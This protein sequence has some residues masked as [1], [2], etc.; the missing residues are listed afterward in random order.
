MSR[1]SVD[2]QLEI[3]G[4]GVVPTVWADMREPLQ[5][6][7]A[8]GR[9]LRVKC[10]FDPTA[11]DLHIG[12]TVVMNK[13][14]QF[15]D[16]GHEVTF[17]VGDFTAMIGDP[18][19]KSQT[20][21][22]LTRDE[23]KANAKTYMDQVVKVLDASRSKLR[24]NSEWLSEMGPED[25]IRLAARYTVA[26]MMERNDFR[27]RF[28]NG[29][30]IAIHEFLYPLLQAYDSVAM[31]SDV[32]LGGN[33][34]LFNLMVG[35]EVMREYGLAPQVILTTPLLIGLD[36]KLDEN[37]QLVGEKMSKSL[38]NYVGIDDP[39]SGENGMYGKLMSISDPLMW[40]YYDL[41]SELTPPELEQRKAS[42]HPKEAKAALAAEIT[43]RFHSAEAAE[44]ARAD[45]ERLHPSSGGERGVPDDVESVELSA[46]GEPSMFLSRALVESGLAQSNSAARRLIIQGGVQ[47][48]GERVS[49]QSHALPLGEYLIKA[50]KRRFRR[51]VIK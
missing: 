26:R 9:P 40:H 42:M 14:K 48:D 38:G 34:Q 13:M 43:T 32:E 2:E 30:A 23:V 24:Y 16:L 7:L 33:D 36:G 12:H 50:G 35:R 49:D 1:V 29:V 6:K 15:Q 3:L 20:R 39:P 47:V 51:V 37:G 21:P 44:Q 28:Q 8:E 46:D 27:N 25:L 4:K 19:G 31:K 22:P 5:K 11:P 10:G 17:L 45:F 18:T 41:L